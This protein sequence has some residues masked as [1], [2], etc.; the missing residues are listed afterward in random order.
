[1]GY[2]SDT[3]NLFRDEYAKV[4]LYPEMLEST[5]IQ[6]RRN[7]R[8]LG[9][10]LNTTLLDQ[11]DLTKAA[12]CNLSESFE[13]NNSVDVGYTDAITGSKKLHMLGLDGKY[14]EI[15][16]EG[17]SSIRGLNLLGGMIDVPGP[18]L[19]SI[20]L[21]KGSGS[22]VTGREAISGQIVYNWKPLIVM[23]DFMSMSTS[24]RMGD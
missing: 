12:C 8:Q 5:V 18:F 9:V 16:F 24:A 7:S 4:I 22:I 17:L 13:T 1:M 19:H 20:A 2:T 11:K 6:S 21:S 3:L 10:T 15:R 14:A 23:N